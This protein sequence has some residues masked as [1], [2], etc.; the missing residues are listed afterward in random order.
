MRC[1]VL[2]QAIART[3]CCEMPGTEVWRWRYQAFGFKDCRSTV[4]G[5]RKRDGIKAVQRM[6]VL[7]STC[8]QQYQVAN[9]LVRAFSKV[10]VEVPTR[11]NG[12]V[13]G[14]ATAARDALATTGTIPCMVLRSL[15]DVRY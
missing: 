15:G 5:L 1:P 9:W 14:R 12:T 10:L 8:A 3:I 2:T 11:G 13:R 4:A 7:Y 6:P